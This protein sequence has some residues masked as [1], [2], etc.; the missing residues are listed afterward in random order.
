MTRES[1][2]KTFPQGNPRGIASLMRPSDPALAISH[3]LSMPF[4]VFYSPWT[5]GVADDSG[6]QDLRMSAEPR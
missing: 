5:S 2:Q 3:L 1:N 4:L 6:L